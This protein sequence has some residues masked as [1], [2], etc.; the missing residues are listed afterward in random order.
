[1]AL[2]KENGSQI[3]GA[4]SFANESD[5]DAY[6]DD[7]GITPASGDVE[8]ALVRST[9]AI[10]GMY[11]GRWSGTKTSSDQALSW[12]RSGATD[13]DG[14]TID[15]DQIPAVLVQAVCEGAI[16]ELA[17]AGKLTPDLPRG[18][19]IQSVQAGSVGV[20]YSEYAP[21]TTTFTAI[22]NLLR[23]LVGSYGVTRLVRA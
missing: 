7:R 9:Q 11:R 17:K 14:N 19:A 22:E 4:N 2:V 8:A 18:G 10:E 16:R 20:T 23:G 5:F 21:G 1:M 15:D 3:D 12:P 6:C 13:E